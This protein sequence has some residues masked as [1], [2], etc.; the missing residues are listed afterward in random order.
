MRYN[1]VFQIRLSESTKAML[2]EIQP[3]QKAEYI[4]LAIKVINCLTDDKNPY[5]GE[6]YIS[7]FGVEKYVKK[8]Y[9]QRFGNDCPEIQERK[10]K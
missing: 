9:E 5:N 4:R 8:L 7:R 1:E 2:D 6:N 3:R 10:D